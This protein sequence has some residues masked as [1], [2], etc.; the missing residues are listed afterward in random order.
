MKVPETLHLRATRTKEKEVPIP[1][2]Q[3]SIEPSWLRSF[4]S[5]TDPE[6]PP[7]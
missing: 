7:F 5:F 6:I 4:R 1:S 2:S 3:R